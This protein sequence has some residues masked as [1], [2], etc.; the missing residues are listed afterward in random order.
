MNLAWEYTNTSKSIQR[1][2][3]DQSDFNTASLTPVLI[4]WHIRIYSYYASHDDNLINPNLENKSKFGK[5]L[6]MMSPAT[7]VINKQSHQ[8][9][10]LSMV[11]GS[12]E[13]SEFNI[14]VHLHV[15]DK[16]N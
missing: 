6:L 7:L 2:A 5:S 9:L 10:R 3:L 15:D 12:L 16:K 13:A 8:P 11:N 4:A 1:R 14:Q